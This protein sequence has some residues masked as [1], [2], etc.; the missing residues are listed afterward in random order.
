MHYRH[1]LVRVGLGALVAALLLFGRESRA[2][3][4][5]TPALAP[6]AAPASPEPVKAKAPSG[7][8]DAGVVTDAGADAVDA[9]GAEDA[10]V[11]DAAV[12][13]AAPEP[14]PPP[15]EKAAPPPSAVPEPLPPPPPAPPASA[16]PLERG[17]AAPVK[18]GDTVVFSLFAPRG[19]R[20][21][22]QRARAATKALGGIIETAK[23]EDVR[24]TRQGEV[25][26]VMV[27]QTPIVQ[28]GETDA[29]L[30]GDSSLD[31]HAAN[32]A[33]QLRRAIETE[34]KRSAIAKLVFSISLVVFFALIAVYLMRKLG[35]FADRARVWLEERGDK[36]LTVRIRDIEVL[37]PA[38]IQSTALVALGLGKWLGQF[39]I[40]YT[41]L[42]VVLSLFDAT[43][44]YTQRLTGF[45]VAPLS[46]MM[47]R[48][49]TSLPLLVILSIAGL[50]V[51]V[52]VRF[53]RLFFRSVERR[54]TVVPWMPAELA[55]AASV[56]IRAGII[57]LALMLAGPVVTGDDQGALSRLSTV[58]LAALGLA[59][60]PLL[61][62]GLIGTYVVFA[63]RLRVGHHVEIAGHSGRIAGLDLMEVRLE[64]RTRGELRFPHLY[65]LRQPTRVFGLRPR[66]SLDVVVA[67]DEKPLAV[68]TLLE[69]VGNRLG[70][71]VSVELVHADLRGLV[72]RIT[73]SSDST[74]SRSELSLAVLD[75]LSSEG[76][77]LGLGES[78]VP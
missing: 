6:S 11:E 62:N 25:A 23:G 78:K 10:A 49:A 57:L 44:G 41:W 28:L 72:Y 52:L 68:L 29:K 60:V 3:E 4:G 32:V 53:V 77:K 35:D 14:P 50:A 56:V 1:L 58:A 15:V 31:V 55:G 19:E 66:I 47:T 70:R 46:E 39:G 2:Q 75:A 30:A 61:A 38:T 67:A 64:E 9:A 22:E 76:I 34:R 36:G 59:A 26:V 5:T 7:A 71:D 63:R 48:L 43:R 18:L 12:E 69:Q 24:V 21:P 8:P 51:Y 17:E 20:P 73:L 45:V 27:G 74:A 54:E 37:S 33:A 65:L 40:L 13:Q 42:V 16:P